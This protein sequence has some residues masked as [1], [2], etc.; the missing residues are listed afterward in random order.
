MFKRVGMCMLGC[1]FTT[2][3]LT[4]IVFLGIF[5]LANPDKQ[6]FYGTFED[7]GV[8]YATREKAIEASAADVIDVHARFVNWCLWG[9]IMALTPLPIGAFTLICSC[10]NAQCGKTV[11]GVGM[12]FF[13]CSLLAWWITGIVWRFRADGRYS[14]GDIPPEGTSDID[15]YEKKILAADSLF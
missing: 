11:G 9:F 6:A 12:C 14:C 1:T 2:T 10:I 8:L 5:G 13:N 7:K 4:T 3:V 15:F